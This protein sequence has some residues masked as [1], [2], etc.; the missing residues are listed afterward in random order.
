MITKFDKIVFAIIVIF[1]I[2]TVVFWKDVKSILG[3][4]STVNEVNIEKD[5]NNRKDKKKDKKDKKDDAS[6]IKS[7]KKIARELLCYMTS[8]TAYIHR[9]DGNIFCVL[10][11]SSPYL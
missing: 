1:L 10:P 8:S 2:V 11:S 9:T 4:K 6:I 7:E 3:G 5:K